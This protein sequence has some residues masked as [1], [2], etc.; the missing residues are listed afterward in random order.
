[1]QFKTDE[2]TDHYLKPEYMPPSFH[3]PFWAVVW[4]L[5]DRFTAPE[6]S[7]GV[8]WT[9]VIVQVIMTIAKLARRKGV[10]LAIRN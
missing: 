5:M 3:F 2:T 10:K 7:Y 1:M 4:L 9:F 8:Y 6:W